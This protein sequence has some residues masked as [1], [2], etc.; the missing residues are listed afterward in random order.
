MTKEELKHYTALKRAGYIFYLLEKNNDQIHDA[1]IIESY[2]IQKKVLLES[3]SPSDVKIF[4][5]TISFPY[6]LS[7]YKYL[8]HQKLS[9]NVS[10]H[11]C[12]YFGLSDE[13]LEE[14]MKE[15]IKYSYLDLVNNNIDSKFSS[16][17]IKISEMSEQNINLENNSH[18]NL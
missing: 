8:E 5:N 18:K 6:D 2:Q 9:S 3:L 16:F 15:Y 7:L 4:L 11:T 1:N 12:E 10:A 17:A 14:K 13:L